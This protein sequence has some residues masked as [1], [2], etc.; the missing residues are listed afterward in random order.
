[1]EEISD[2]YSIRYR[3]IIALA[4]DHGSSVDL[5]ECFDC[6]GGAMWA[7]YHYSKSPLVQSARM[8][9]SQARYRL[10]LG[11][12]RLDLMGSSFPAGISS[13]G[14]DEREIAITYLGMGG[15][16]VGAS[17]CRAS[18][19][20]VLRNTCDESG[21][22]RVAGSTIWLPRRERVLIGVDDTD[23]PEAGATWTLAHNIAK[24]VEDENSRYL[25]HTIVQLFPVPA[26]TKNCVAT[27]CEFA[28]S[29]PDMLVGQYAR[30]LERYTLSD[31]TGMA[32]YRGF[33]P[34]ALQTFGRSVKRGEVSKEA[35][36]EID[37]Q[38]LE[39]VI[40][41]RGI[42]GAVAAIPFYTNF[43]EALELWS[44]RS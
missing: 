2:P 18:S 32:V 6:I 8:I 9:G 23:T 22:G 44:G 41:G 13:V 25:S 1:M 29:D 26:R 27:V 20:G 10:S 38:R 35:L 43:E 5:I 21:G 17:I 3:E 37:D 40:D 14:L 15:G 11:T 31:K 36:A 28:T 16:G 34:A 30:L 42:I 4:D 33:D 19:P 39:I 7:K 24:A 12:V